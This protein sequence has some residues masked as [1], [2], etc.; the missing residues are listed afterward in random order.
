MSEY[1]LFKRQAEVAEKLM[2]GSMVLN[3]DMRLGKT[4]AVLHAFERM[5]WNGGPRTLLVICP[6]IAKGVWEQEA[7]EM[8]LEIPTLVLEGIKK[9]VS[10]GDHEPELPHMM[11]L[12]WE[13]ADAW[14]SE[15]L[16]LVQSRQ[17]VLVLDETH[18]HCTN[19]QNA[20]YKAVRDLAFFAERVWLLTG[21]LYRTSALDLH[22]QLKLLGSRLYPHYYMK[23]VDFGLKFCANVKQLSF[24]KGERM[25]TKT[26]YAGI[27]NEAELIAGIPIDRR[28]EDLVEPP[29]NVV[30]WLDEGHKYHYSGGS[31]DGAMAKARNELALLKAERVIELVKNNELIKEPLV[32]FGWHKAFIQR[33][34]SGLLAEFP[35]LR[36][37]VI[38]GNVDSTQKTNIAR[39]FAAGQLD[40]VIANIDAAG[41]SVDLAAARNAV[42]GEIDWVK[43]TMS[44]AEARIRGPRQTRKPCYWYPLCLDSVDEFVWRT[45]LG[46]GRDM[47]RLDAAQMAV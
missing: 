38:S 47:K 45:M 19:P 1:H 37:G 8:G 28:L 27:K 5:T 25:I 11:I 13:I 23:T 24:R 42:F 43:A 22:W 10:K 18:R 6:S 40:V 34:L 46:R 9:K 21:T 2:A 35:H 15:L 32:I 16:A 7:R 17:V 33:V 36:I 14:L 29:E 39:A 4:R 3:W 26:E 30:W 12:N 20:R 31:E 41:M 44:Q